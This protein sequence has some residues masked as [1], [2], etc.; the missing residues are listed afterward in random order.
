MPFDTVTEQ[1]F[2]CYSSMESWYFVI[3]LWPE[4]MVGVKVQILSLDTK[5]ER[6][7]HVNH[8]YV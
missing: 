3:F 1:D 4:V 5:E 8:T 7:C 2:Y 6:W